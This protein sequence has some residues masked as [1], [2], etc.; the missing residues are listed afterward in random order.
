MPEPLLVAPGAVGGAAAALPNDGVRGLFGLWN[1]AMATLDADEVAKRYDEAP[2]LLPTI[3]NT[4][5]TDYDGIKA[6][7]VDFL[8]KEPQGTILESYVTSGPD[9]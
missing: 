1:D 3:S 4:P 8:K 2:C 5:R 7:F 9:W 6:Y